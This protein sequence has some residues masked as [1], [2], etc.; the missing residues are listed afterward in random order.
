M[1]EW[2]NFENP[3]SE[4]PLI[5][6]ILDKGMIA[7]LYTVSPLEL[8]TAGGKTLRAGLM[9]MGFTHPDFQGKGYY[10]EL[11]RSLHDQ[12]QLEGYDVIFG[13]ANHNSHYVY[14]K[15]LGWEDVAILNN[16]CFHADKAK[17]HF[18]GQP[19]YQ[20]TELELDSETMKNMAGSWVSEGCHQGIRSFSFLKWRL[21]D[22]PLH[23]YKLAGVFSGADQIASFVYKSHQENEIDL[24][25]VFFTLPGRLEQGQVFHS[26]C[27]YLFSTGRSVLNF[28]SNLFS[29][30]H[31]ELEKLGFT[32]E[33]AMT[34]FG[35]IDF[36]G[37]P[38]LTDTRKWHYRFLDSDVY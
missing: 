1:W 12:L 37:T 13:F 14:R 2:R 3:Y 10:L 21:L 17:R 34:Y 27:R 16:F 6:Y 24:M 18:Y 36:S 30:E 33:I 26:I 20:V 29:T 35:V 28:W 25:E 9:N 31:L 8:V 19:A 15:Y 22:N 32:E 38:D 23:N 11:N 4:K 7:S 5:A